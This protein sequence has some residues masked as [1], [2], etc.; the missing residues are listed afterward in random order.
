MIQSMMFAA[1]S[2]GVDSISSWANLTATGV[3]CALLVWIITKAFPAMLE[4]HDKVQEETRMHNERRIEVIDANRAAS[5]REGH[6]AAKELSKSIQA[7][8][9]TIRQ[10][11][12]AVEKLTA[13]IDIVRP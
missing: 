7:G 8:N 6:E 3:I 11:T 1:E 12:F 2:M 4:R 13:K 10:N 9:E 5:A